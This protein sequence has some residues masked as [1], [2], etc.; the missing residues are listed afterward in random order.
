M[1]KAFFEASPY[2][3]LGIE[4]GHVRQLVDQFTQQVVD[5]LCVCLMDGEKAV[6]VLGAVAAKNIFN[7]R[8][9]CVEI[10]WWIDP[11]YRGYQSARKMVELY[12]Y[13]ATHKIKAQAIQLITLDPSY[14]AFYKRMGFSKKEEAYI[15]EL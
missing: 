7:S 2:A 10:M 9:S 15:K 3:P 6:G 13:W 11:E 4:E 1:A 8:Y 14:G 12:E 5:K